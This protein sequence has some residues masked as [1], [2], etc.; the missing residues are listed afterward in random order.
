MM[1]M[2]VTFPLE[3]KGPLSVFA[4]LRQIDFLN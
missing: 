1:V 2:I 4:F 3:R